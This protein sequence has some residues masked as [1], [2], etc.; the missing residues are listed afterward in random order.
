MRRKDEETAAQ[1]CFVHRHV[2]LTERTKG[3]PQ[4][5]NLNSHYKD[6]DT[7]ML[8]LRELQMDITRPNASLIFV[9]CY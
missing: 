9:R 7:K 8:G 1:D 3:V 6:D 5:H 4:V 2:G